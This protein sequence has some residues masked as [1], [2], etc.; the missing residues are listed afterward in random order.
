MCIYRQ[1]IPRVHSR[2][3]GQVQ[4][5]QRAAAACMLSFENRVDRPGDCE[6]NGLPAP[7]CLGQD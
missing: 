3:T 2:G 1:T 5:N 7:D 6:Y 4:E